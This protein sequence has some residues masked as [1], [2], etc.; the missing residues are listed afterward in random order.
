MA[1]RDYEWERWVQENE[2]ALR[3]IGIPEKCWATRGKLGIFCDDGKSQGFDVSTLSDTS[4]K[5]LARYFESTYDLDKLSQT[6]V[7][8]YLHYRF[9]LLRTMFNLRG[10]WWQKALEYIL[11]YTAEQRAEWMR[12]REEEY[13]SQ[14][15]SAASADPAEVFVLWGIVPFADRLDVIQKEHQAVVKNIARL[16]PPMKVDR[17]SSDWRSVAAEIR[18]WCNNHSIPTEAWPVETK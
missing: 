7:Y 1:R 4:A 15:F 9:D 11:D 6:G 2:P 17:S 3:E 18:D 14:P 10:N 5:K 8:N 12:E 16:L 13:E